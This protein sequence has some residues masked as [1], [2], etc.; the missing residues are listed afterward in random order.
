MWH[1]G[2]TIAISM[3]HLQLA[4]LAFMRSPSRCRVSSAAASALHASRNCGTR[5]ASEYTCSALS[6]S[7]KAPPDAFT[8]L[9]DAQLH[10]LMY[11]RPMRK[12]HAG[13]FDPLLECPARRLV[14]PM[15]CRATNVRR[16]LTEATN[17]S[18][19]PVLFYELMT[20]E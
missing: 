17:T 6:R 11:T 20:S 10:G 4:W 16:F 7:L 2:C 12:H 9:Q 8:A 19:V 15:S 1:S 13:A 18:G 3:P 14:R 5:A